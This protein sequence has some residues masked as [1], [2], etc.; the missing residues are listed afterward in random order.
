[1]LDIFTPSQLATLRAMA[2][3]II[4]ADAFPAGWE[5]GVEGYLRRQL[6][7]DLR[8]LVGTYRDGLD[9]LDAEARA[10]GGPF[11][12]L[13]P[14]EQDQLLARVEQGAVAAPWPV[15]PAAFFRMA[16]AHAAEGYYSDPGNGGNRNHVAWR[17][18]GFE[19]RG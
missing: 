13:A 3:R 18:I 4:P 5:G 15:D 7:G 9:A 6:A 14:A 12:A 2:N 17:M 10:A 8:H 11:I 1:M 19:V 16:V